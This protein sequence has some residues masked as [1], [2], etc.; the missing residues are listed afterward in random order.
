MFEREILLIN[1]NNLNKIKNKKVLVIGVGGVGSF[2]VEGLIRA[3]I[4]NICVIDSDKVDISNKNRQ[5]IALDS[6][7]GKNKVDV[8]YDRIKDIN[9]D[10]KVLKECIFLTKDNTSDYI[11]K[12]MPDYVIDC[13]DTVTVKFEIIKTC[14]KNN[15]KFITCLGTGNR[16][17]PLK[18][19]ITDLKK[20]SYDPLAKILRKLVKENNIKGSIPVLLNKSDIIKNTNKIIGSISFVPSVGGLIIASYIINDIIKKK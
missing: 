13:C 18:Y 5:L 4:N 14:I 7:I 15:I 8:I 1:D 3:G 12:Y 10:C 16:L 11:L 2:V 6:T 17:D 9:K 19:E 20:T